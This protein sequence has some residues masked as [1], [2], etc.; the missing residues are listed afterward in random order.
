MQRDTGI[1][2]STY[3]KEA[4]RVLFFCKKTAGSGLVGV[5]IILFSSSL[6]YKVST[7]IL[8]KSAI[9]SID[10]WICVY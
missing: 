8:I 10:N 2:T 5:S 6:I 9:I 4:N 7:C 1:N 3:S